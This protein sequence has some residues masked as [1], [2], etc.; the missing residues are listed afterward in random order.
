MAGSLFDD[1]MLKVGGKDWTFAMN[2]LPQM[3]PKTTDE[4]INDPITFTSFIQGA[5]RDTAGVKSVGILLDMH[6]DIPEF[7]FGQLGTATQTGN[8][9]SLPACLRPRPEDPMPTGAKVGF[10]AQNNEDSTVSILRIIYFKAPIGTRD[11]LK[12]ANGD[13]YVPVF[14]QGP[15]AVKKSLTSLLDRIPGYHV[16]QASITCRVTPG[17]ERGNS[18]PQWQGEYSN[19]ELRLGAKFI[20]KDCP[21]CDAESEQYIWILQQIKH[22]SGSPIAGWPEA[23]VLKMADSKRKAQQGAECNTQFPLQTYSLKP[24]LCDFLLPLLYPLLMGFGVLMVGWPEVGKTPLFIVLAMAMGRYHIDRLGLEN[25]S[26]GWR[27][28]KTFDQFRHRNARVQEAMFVDDPNRQ[29]VDLEDMKSWLCVSE[30]GSASARYDDAKT[31]KNGLRGYAGNDMVG[32]DEEPDDDGTHVVSFKE[33]MT[34]LRKTFPTES[35]THILAVLKRSILFIW[36]KKA[37]Y[38]RLPSSDDTMV[39]HRITD[40][41]VHLDV[42]ADHDKSAYGKYKDDIMEF[43]PNFEQDV[44]REQR[45]I[46]DSM[47]K[48]QEYGIVDEYIKYCNDAIQSKLGEVLSPWR[49]G[50]SSAEHDV[51]VAATPDDELARSIPGNNDGTWTIPTVP[52]GSGATRRSTFSIPPARRLRKKTSE[53]DAG[54][55]SMSASSSTAAA[56]SPNIPPDWEMDMEAAT[57]VGLG[58]SSSFDDA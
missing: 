6:K 53:T 58:G 55:P 35:P 32:P 44:Q 3:G 9:E 41:D 28:A 45:M 21:G 49:T 20:H 12:Y 43:P 46:K 34:M 5:C 13:P 17:L 54:R 48:R 10:I 14:R 27:R 2:S 37:L 16:D 42:L 47:R 11:A 18:K 56:S 39:V 52:C 31:V 22:D 25:A 33:L 29:K 24:V 8:L 1:A 30:S 23:K 26:P 36:G 51:H 38:I 40:F 57:L 19:D 50:P 4:H 15:W 7:A